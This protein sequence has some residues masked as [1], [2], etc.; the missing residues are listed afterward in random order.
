MPWR[1]LIARIDA[2]DSV[3][4]DDAVFMV[5]LVNLFVRQ[6][7]SQ[8][9][10][11]TRGSVDDGVRATGSYGP[12]P[13]ALT[14]VAGID[15][16]PYLELVAEFADQS[17]AQVWEDDFPSFRRRLMLNPVLLL[18]GFAP[19]IGRAEL[20]R[21]ERT[22][23]LRASVTTEELQRLLAVVTNFARGVVGRPQ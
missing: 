13:Q 23:F 10:P 7:A 14:L 20:S 1:D 8:V 12:P 6:E 18:G 2:E 3:L 16:E 19:L 5:T 11:G 22:L 15:P 17:G 21:E 4:P 9:V